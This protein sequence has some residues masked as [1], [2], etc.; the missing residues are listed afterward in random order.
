MAGAEE[1]MNELEQLRRKTV[2]LE[3]ENARIL[4]QS[5][6]RFFK[7]FHASANPM[8]ITSIQNGKVLDINRTGASL[9][10]YKREELIGSTTLGRHL[11]VYPQQR[12]EVVKQLQEEGAVHNI[13]VEL[14]NAESG[15]SRTVLFSAN[16]ITMDNEPCLLSILV[17]ITAREK[18]SNDLRESEEKYRTL[19]ENSLQGLAIIQ[20]S[21]IVFCNT[22]FAKMLEYSIEEIVALSPKQLE[23]LVHPDD[24]SFFIDCDNDGSGKSPVS[25]RFECRGIRKDGTVV[26]LEV[27]SSAIDY[28]GKPAIQSA[29]ID[30]T[31]RKNAE[32]ALRESD[33]RFRLIAET[34][35]EIFWMNDAENQRV[36]YVSPAHDR[37]WQYPRQSLYDN[38]KCFYDHIHPDDRD[39]TAEQMALMKTGQPVDYEYRIIRPDGSIR[40]IWDRGFPVVDKT[41]RINR[42]VG[43]AQDVTAR[44]QTEAAVKESREYLNRVINCIKDPIFVKDRQHRFVLVN[45]ASCEFSGVPR[46]RMLGHT[47]FDA[48]PTEQAAILWEQEE[49]IFNTGKEVVTEEELIN[50]RGEARSIM[51]KKALLI[52]NKGN[53]QIVGVLRDITEYKR[54]ESQFAQAQKM[55]AIG[56]LA[57]GIAHDFNNLLSVI[58]GYAEMLMEDFDLGDRRRADVEQIEKAGQR[59]AA[60]ISQLLAFGRKQ[61]LQPEI[62]DLNGIVADMSAMLRRLIG[63]DIELAAVAQPDLGSINADP[64]QV[65]QIIM[66]IAVNSRDAMPSGGKLTIETAN[67]DLDENYVREHPIVAPGSYV[68]LAIS[69]NGIGMDAETQSR[70]FEPFFTTKEKGKGTGLGLSTVYGIVKQSNGFIWVY[71]EPGKGTTFKIYFPRVKGEISQTASEVNS[72]CG[73]CKGETVLIAEDEEAVRALAS[74]ML[75]ARGYS[76]LEASDGVEALRLAQ[77]YV[78]P[79][80]LVL[81]DVIMPGMG[82]SMLVHQLEEARPGIKSLYISGYADNSIVHHGVL[83][84]TVAF[85]QKP[86]TLEGLTRKLREVIDSK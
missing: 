86:F 20:D 55:E 7:L 16:P 64:G 61:M 57:G 42:F 72:E 68:M 60:L 12:N 70:I 38:P 17:D 18:E 81:T 32:I 31:E 13:N 5:E 73:S 2:E 41:G 44:R 83:D 47:G 26:W 84:S 51:S 23:V 34:I 21:R 45:E 9:C 85:L 15:D 19:V 24:R 36:L 8:A 29:F 4:R 66:N 39:R 50:G 40:Q 37:I 62:L 65:Q 10:G 28:H 27:F 52:D 77:E 59:A 79:I 22:A 14:L 53:K 1:P 6:E 48:M 33:E 35:D 58:K 67:A 46:A 74:R 78:G 30:I 71:S 76:V 82:G 75:R 63:E 80:H 43:V 56:V 25:P 11:W 3:A 49:K 69:D 54:L